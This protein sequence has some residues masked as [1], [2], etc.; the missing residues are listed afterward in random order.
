MVSLI[1]LA[2]ATISNMSAQL[3]NIRIQTIVELQVFGVPDQLVL[4]VPCRGCFGSATMVSSGAG[5]C[6]GRGRT[7]CWGCAG[8][9][10][11]G[12]WILWIEAI[13]SEMVSRDLVVSVAVWSSWL[14]IWIGATWGFGRGCGRVGV[15]RWGRGWRVVAKHFWFVLCVDAFVGQWWWCVAGATWLSCAGLL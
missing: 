4:D 5:S 3:V 9:G 10:G 8:A 14:L 7:I 1:D 15:G 13:G 11:R 12:G 2:E 6:V